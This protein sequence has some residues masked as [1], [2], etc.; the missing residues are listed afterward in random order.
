LKQRRED[1]VMTVKEFIDCGGT[2]RSTNA[3]VLQVWVANDVDR[4]LQRR[5]W[6]RSWTSP[7]RSSSPTN[8]PSRLNTK[9]V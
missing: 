2:V 1:L 4:R 6:R 9:R 7:L 5:N 3:C 8:C